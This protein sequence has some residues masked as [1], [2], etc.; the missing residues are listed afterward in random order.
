MKKIFDE[1]SFI[2]SK[3]TTQLYS[4]SFS[5]GILF[6]DKSIRTPIYSLYGF[7]RLA[8]EIV[9]SFQNYNQQQL[10]IKF[11]Q[12]T[13]DSIAQRIS[14]NPILNAFQKI[15]HLYNIKIEYI[16]TFFNSME[17]DLNDVQYDKK[18]YEK[19]ILGSAEVVGLMC[20]QIFTDNN[21]TLFE[22]LKPYSMHLGAAFQK[23]NFLRDLKD[24]F[25]LLNRTYFPN[26]EIKNFTNHT[27][28][29][30][31]LEIEMDFKEALVGIKLLPKKA[32]LG[33]Y[34]AYLYYFALFKRIKKSSANTILTKRIRIPNYK[35]FLIMIGS[36]FS[37]QLKKI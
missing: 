35:K 29:N 27:K 6:L 21:N 34:L 18:K 23:I 36:F 10:L 3:K 33:V 16:D 26:L 30:I 20:L 22:K 9:D 14:I 4:T 5:T 1:L 7:V 19:Y 28:A 25:Y 11:K 15:V 37:V 8:D 12:D 24:D 32:K 17:M 31:E 2:C 13:Y